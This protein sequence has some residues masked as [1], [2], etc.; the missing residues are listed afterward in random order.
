MKITGYQ[1]SK[2]G[3][4]FHLADTAEEAEKH[5]GEGTRATPLFN[6]FGL[7][8]VFFEAIGHIVHNHSKKDPE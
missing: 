5:A 4:T 6:P 8:I 3:H 1:A 2:D 7:F